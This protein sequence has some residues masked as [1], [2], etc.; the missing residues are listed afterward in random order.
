M[1]THIASYPGHAAWVGGYHTHYSTIGAHKLEC[2]LTI[3]VLKLAVGHRTF[4]AQYVN[5]SGHSIYISS[6]I[7][8]KQ[9]IPTYYIILLLT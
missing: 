5:L 1:A 8:S 9:Q 2:T 3:P 6:D 4:S 7:M